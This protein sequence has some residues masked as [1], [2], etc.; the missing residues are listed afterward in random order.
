MAKLLRVDKNGTKY[1]EET[2]CPKC[3]GRGYLDYYGHIEQGRCFECGGSGYKVYRWKEY[4]EEYQK[5]LEQRRIKKLIKNAPKEN[6]AFLKREGFDE[7]G[8][9]WIVLGKTFEIKDELKEAG[10]KFSPN[11]GWHFNHETEYETVMINVE[12]VTYK[13]IYGYFSFNDYESVKSAIE[14]KLPK[15]DVKESN[16]IGSI[17]EK[18][19][20]N[21]ELIK[22]AWYVINSYK[23]YGTETVWVYTFAD[24]NGNNLV[25]K[26]SSYPEIEEGKK[27][28]LKGTIKDHNEYK[29]IK[30]TIMNRCKFVNI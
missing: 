27:Y 6:E 20:I 14:S 8:N 19:E 29:N 10:A 16:Y 4:T 15:K 21:V 26:T 13:S 28:I 24:E 12:E 7:N 9:T 11:L 25:W 1:W 22:Q 17:G 5:V 3:H 30:Q 23:G 18:I 2:V